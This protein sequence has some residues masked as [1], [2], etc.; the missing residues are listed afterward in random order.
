[1]KKGEA[2]EKMA[3][4]LL[5]RKERNKTDAVSLGFVNLDPVLNPNPHANPS[6]S[7]P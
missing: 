7:P 4:H 6:P 5:K 2:K 1:M 3:W